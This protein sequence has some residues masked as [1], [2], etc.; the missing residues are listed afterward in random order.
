MLNCC[1]RFEKL[2]EPSGSR[3]LFPMCT[4]VRSCSTRPLKQKCSL[5]YYPT[6]KDSILLPFQHI[7][8]E[9]SEC[10]WSNG[11]DKTVTSIRNHFQ[12]KMPVW[13]Q[14]HVKYR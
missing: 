9:Q 10:L 8:T 7:N 14:K 6:Y 2:M 1:Q 4:N 11:T 3:S 12:Y 5:H 13:F